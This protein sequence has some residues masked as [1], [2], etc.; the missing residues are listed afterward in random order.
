MIIILLS[1]M[2]Y[3]NIEITFLKI[4]LQLGTTLLSAAI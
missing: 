1:D 2:Q 4:L 3:Q